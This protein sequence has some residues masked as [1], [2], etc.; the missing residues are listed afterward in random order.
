MTVERRKFS[1]DLDD[2]NDVA[3]SIE[4]VLDDARWSGLSPYGYRGTPGIV[5]STGNEVLTKLVTAPTLKLTERG[6]LKLAVPLKNTGQAL[7]KLSECFQKT[8]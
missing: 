7:K 6:S 5:K 2:E 4:L 3:H 1:A 8:R